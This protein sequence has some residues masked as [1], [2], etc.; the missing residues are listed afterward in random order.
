MDG[1]W[2]IAWFIVAMIFLGGELVLPGFILLPFGLSAIVASIVAF[3]GAPVGVAWAVFIIGGGLGFGLFWKFARE[4][5]ADL[6]NPEGV[7]ADRLVGVVGS[8]V[9]PIP[10]VP[11]EAGMVKIGGEKWR[12]ES[13]DGRPVAEGV[14]VDVVKVR[15]TRVVVKVHNEG[16]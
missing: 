13:H 3:L 8:V 9:E 5:L 16:F 11:G 6:P 2:G 12:A 1:S 10:D 14:V 4:N 7:G 15:G